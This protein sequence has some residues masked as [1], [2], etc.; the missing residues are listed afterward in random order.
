MLRWHFLY[1]TESF[2]IH[3]HADTQYNL[4]LSNTDKILLLSSR[5]RLNSDD[6]LDDRSEDYRDNCLRASL[7]ILVLVQS[8]F[9]LCIF[10]TLS[11]VNRLPGKTHLWN[12]LLCVECDVKPYTHTHSS[13]FASCPVISIYIQYCLILSFFFDI[14]HIVSVQENKPVIKLS[15]NPVRSVSA[16]LVI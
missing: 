16:M 10:S 13:Q 9:F 11:V 3:L 1:F 2:F 14:A 6:C 5:H 7:F 8:V 4:S 12:Y 15:W